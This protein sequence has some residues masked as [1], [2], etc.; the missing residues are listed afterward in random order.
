MSDDF[1]GHTPGP[2]RMGKGDPVNETHVC[3]VR[4]IDIWGPRAIVP[5][6]DDAM[7]IVSAPELDAEVARLTYALGHLDKMLAY[8]I[9]TPIDDLQGNLNYGRDYISKTL[10]GG[11]D[12]TDDTQNG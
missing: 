10:R 1:K 6:G 5:C 9:D 11:K 12:E 7:F 3:N 8:D 4:G 2:W